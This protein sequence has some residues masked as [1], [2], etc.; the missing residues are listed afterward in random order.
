MTEVTTKIINKLGV[1][2][3]PASKFVQ[4][5]MRFQSDIHLEAKGVQEDAKSI[6]GVMRLGL[7]KDVSVKIIADGIDEEKA[8]AELSDFLTK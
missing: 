3:R 2:A 1:H 7:S 5:A 8:V 4:E 6:L